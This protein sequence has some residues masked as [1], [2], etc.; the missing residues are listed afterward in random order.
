MKIRLL[1]LMALMGMFVAK[2]DDKQLSTKVVVTLS[3]ET[4]FQS[5]IYPEKYNETHEFCPQQMTV[6][7]YDK[8]QQLAVVFCDS[9]CGIIEVEKKSELEKTIKKAKIKNVIDKL[10]QYYVNEL[11]LI[12]N[13]ISRYYNRKFTQ[14][15]YRYRENF[16][17][18]SIV[19]RDEFLRENGRDMNEILK[20]EAI[21]RIDKSLEG[22]KRLDSIQ[23]S[24]DETLDS[25]ID[26]N[27]LAKYRK[28]PIMINVHGWKTEDY[29]DGISV[30]GYDIINTSNKTIKYVTLS[31]GFDNA[32]DDA[33]RCEITGR[34]YAN[35]RFIGPLKPVVKD[36]KEFKT[37]WDYFGRYETDDNTIFYSRV[38]HY[39]R[40]RAIEIEYTDGTKRKVTPKDDVNVFY[41]AEKVIPFDL[42]D[43]KMSSDGGHWYEWISNSTSNNN[44]YIEQE[45]KSIENQYKE[46]NAKYDNYV[47]LVNIE[48]DES[49]LK[50]FTADGIAKYAKENSTDN[51]IKT[52]VARREVFK[53][54]PMQF[55]P[56]KMD[57]DFRIYIDKNT[58]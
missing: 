34:T 11:A 46:T 1:I 36:N 38:A 17:R 57:G 22:L 15:R 27:Y 12:K 35:Q 13:D 7:S 40:V 45:Y 50:E 29:L 42:V 49:L 5:C 58:P 30:Y 55:Y 6:L 18:D 56:L 3:T 37:R 26:C 24:Y 9:V 39:I 44:G 48:D 4:K 41:G 19:K 28:T 54:E 31:I 32:V 14:L 10:P 8:K 43:D 53:Y 52:N 51:N 16:L 2:A 21:E 20:K 23:K 25:I 33:C 47:P